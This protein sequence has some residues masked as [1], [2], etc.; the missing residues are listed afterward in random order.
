MYKNLVWDLEFFPALR[1]TVRGD[2]L[3]LRRQKIDRKLAAMKKARVKTLNELR[4]INCKE[5]GD[6]TDQHEN[7]DTCRAPG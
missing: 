2:D 5:G 1:D 4:A 3:P 6:G 7:T